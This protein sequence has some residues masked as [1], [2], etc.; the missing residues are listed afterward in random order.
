MQL[1]GGE[2]S[3]VQTLALLQAP[4]ILLEAR[5]ILHMWYVPYFEKHR[6]MET[7]HVRDGINWERVEKSVLKPQEWYSAVG[8]LHEAAEIFK[9]RVLGK[10]VFSTIPGSM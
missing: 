10:H 7:T 4:D 6:G 5:D 9:G 3:N 8:D 2:L 1:E